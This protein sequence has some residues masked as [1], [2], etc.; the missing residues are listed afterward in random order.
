VAD[1]FS[2]IRSSLTP[3]LVWIS[4]I[5]GASKQ[6]LLRPRTAVTVSVSRFDVT[7]DVAAHRNGLYAPI[8]PF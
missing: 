2:F 6:L 3:Q 7:C 4:E 5:F 1:L 8:C